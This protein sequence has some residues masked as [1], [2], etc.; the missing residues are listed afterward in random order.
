MTSRSY[1]RELF[2]EKPNFPVLFH[3]KAERWI[4]RWTS[5][6][7]IEWPPA[8][9]GVKRHTATT[10]EQK[11]NDENI[12]NSSRSNQNALFTHILRGCNSY[13]LLQVQYCA[14]YLLQVSLLFF[15]IQTKST[16]ENMPCLK[17]FVFR[18]HIFVLCGK[19]KVHACSHSRGRK[20]S[21]VMNF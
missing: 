10:M 20:K 2:N 5:Y 13:F 19:A 9:A 12:Q 15:S 3:L 18:I 6:L 11:K 4:G 14:V 21:F 7:H 8:R 1:T 16:L 17:T